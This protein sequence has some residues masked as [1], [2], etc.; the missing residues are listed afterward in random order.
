MNNLCTECGKE[1]VDGK[2]WNVK[3]GNSILVYTQTVCPDKKCQKL[4]DKAIADR[5]AKTESLIEKKAKAKLERERLIIE[6]LKT[7]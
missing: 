4:V 7:A 2:T 5:K 1:R 3:S 6:Q